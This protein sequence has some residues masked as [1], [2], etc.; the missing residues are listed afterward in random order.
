MGRNAPMK[1][2][3]HARKARWATCAPRPGLDDP[4][5]CCGRAMRSRDS[6]GPQGSS[7]V[8]RFMELRTKRVA[9]VTPKRRS[10]SMAQSAAGESGAA[11]KRHEPGTAPPMIA[12]LTSARVDTSRLSKRRTRGI[13]SLV[14]VGHFTACSAADD[15]ANTC[16][17]A[18]AHTACMPARTLR[19]D[20][21]ASS[22]GTNCPLLRRGLA[23]GARC[24]CTALT[25]SRTTHRCYDAREKI[26]ELCSPWHWLQAQSN[27]NCLKGGTS[28]A[29]EGEAKERD[30]A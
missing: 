24:C 17:N 16:R 30:T 26:A 23:W 3:S 9:G 6:F 5:A 12:C 27:S 8:P 14:V 1:E 7:Q 28:D 10:P 19:G 2:M 20:L 11:A 18:R 4:T 22:R 21:R 29:Y 15:L 13:A 25:G